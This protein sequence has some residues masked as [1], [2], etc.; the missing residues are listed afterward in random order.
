MATTG[1]STTGRVTERVTVRNYGDM[2]RVEAGEIDA[3][4]VRT[5]ELDAL[6]DTGASHLCLPPD[7]IEKLGLLYSHGREVRT[8]NGVVERRLFKGADVT[9]QGRNEEMS[10][11][12]NDA[13]TPALIG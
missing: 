11:M 2:L 10:V 5:V 1:E 6:V 4:A 13:T 3:D 12:E 9:I 7:V 8:A